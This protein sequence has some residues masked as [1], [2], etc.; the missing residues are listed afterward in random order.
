LEYNTNS[1][2]QS[3]SYKSWHTP[4]TTLEEK[5]LQFVRKLVSGKDSFV[6]RS[7]MRRGE[8]LNITWDM[9][10]G[11]RNKHVIDLK[12]KNKKKIELKLFT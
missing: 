6:G 10:S 5:W 3:Q 11:I 1:A 7:G 4:G 9:S 2:S 8:L 12:S